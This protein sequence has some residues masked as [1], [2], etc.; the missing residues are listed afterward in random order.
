ME[1]NKKKTKSCAQTKTYTCIHTQN[2]KR[3]TPKF[4]DHA[5]N[6]QTNTIP[7]HSSGFMSESSKI[8]GIDTWLELI[9]QCISNKDGFD[10]F[11]EH[12]KHEFAIE[13]LL[14]IT[15]IAIYHTLFSND[16][17]Q[18]LQNIKNK[19]NSNNNN[20]NNSH[21]SL[22]IDQP[23]NQMKLQINDSNNN[24][25]N[26]DNN[27]NDTMNVNVNV[28]VN[29]NPTK[30]MQNMIE[31]NNRNS[32]RSISDLMTL[33]KIIS[34]NN[35]NNNN[36][37]QS[38]ADHYIVLILNNQTHLSNHEIIIPI[39]FKHLSTQIGIQRHSKV[40]N[41]MFIFFNFFNFFL[42]FDSFCF[43]VYC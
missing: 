36:N 29:V 31:L 13:N 39:P 20:N 28:N 14:F 19:K 23:Q 22:N 40:I 9:K 24:N 7:T 35:S 2:K 16:W 12:L 37:N 3:Q 6:T 41:P 26:K 38:L 33:Q 42:L 17:M 1:T 4:G 5:S 21:M 34:N 8:G 25:S 10:L 27:N 11:M 30:F 43:V 15:D 18:Y 32:D